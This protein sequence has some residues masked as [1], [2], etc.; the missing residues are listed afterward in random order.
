MD[1]KTIVIIIQSV[2]IMII[3]SNFVI[4]YETPKNVDPS[5][6]VIGTN[7]DLESL[8]ESRVQSRLIDMGIIERNETSAPVPPK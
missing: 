8:I 7:I 2:V 1:K 3:L 4:V 5:P 6:P